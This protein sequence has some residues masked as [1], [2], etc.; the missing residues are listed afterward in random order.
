MP[1]APDENPAAPQEEVKPVRPYTFW[2]LH[3]KQYRHL[4]EPMPKL[5]YVS[6]K[7]STPNFKISAKYPNIATTEHHQ[8]LRRRG[9]W[10]AVL[11]ESMGRCILTGTGLQKLLMV[12]PL[13]I[14]CQALRV[15]PQKCSP[16]SP[17]TIKK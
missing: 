15:S 5:V 2:E 14:S 1:D 7:P 17:Q 12:I 3:K 9:T 8:W 6:Q 4:I 11:A 10:C 16:K 13:P